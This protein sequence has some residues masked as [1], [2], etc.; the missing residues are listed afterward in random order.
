MNISSEKYFTLLVKIF[1][2][3]QKTL[4]FLFKNVPWYQPSENNIIL[5]GLTFLNREPPRVRDLKVENRSWQILDNPSET[6]PWQPQWNIQKAA[7]D[8]DTP[9]VSVFQVEVYRIV[10]EWVF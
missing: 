10:R 3:Y 8:P 1:L 2:C 4:V 5:S 9:L 7:V 6:N